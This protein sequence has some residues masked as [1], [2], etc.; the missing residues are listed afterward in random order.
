MVFAPRR[1]ISAT[2]RYAAT[3]MEHLAT[4]LWHSGDAPDLPDAFWVGLQ[5]SWFTAHSQTVLAPL[6]EAGHN[7]IVDGWIYKF[8]SK[9]LLQGYTQSDLDVI[10]GRVRVPDAVVLLSAD[11]EALYDR[12]R[13]FRPAELGMHAGYGELNRTTFVDYQRAGLEQLHA[14]AARHAWPVVA[15]DPA[16]TVAES[17]AQLTGVIAGLRGSFPV[18]STEPM[19]AR[20]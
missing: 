20:R 15:L 13:Q 11:P 3:L 18:A 17:T 7:V 19:E 1:Q 9:L 10:F 2:S 16:A 14:Y 4:M 8:C 6:L 5:T 12:R